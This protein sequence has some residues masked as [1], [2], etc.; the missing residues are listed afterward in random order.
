MAVSVRPRISGQWVN[1]DPIGIV[2]VT[3]SVEQGHEGDEPGRLS[4]VG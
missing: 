2:N 1:L 4:A 3:R